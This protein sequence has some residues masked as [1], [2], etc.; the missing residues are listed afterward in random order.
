MEKSLLQTLL[1]SILITTG[2]VKGATLPNAPPGPLSIVLGD[3]FII[4]EADMIL[5]IHG[6]TPFFDSQKGSV[7]LISDINKKNIIRLRADAHQSLVVTDISDNQIPIDLQALAKKKKV[8]FAPVDASTDIKK[9]GQH[10]S[11][12]TITAKEWPTGLNQKGSQQEYYSGS[13]TPG[14]AIFSLSGLG[15]QGKTLLP[16]N[17][18][19]PG[20]ND[21][22]ALRSD[23]LDYP[24]TPAFLEVTAYINYNNYP[25]TGD[26]NDTMILLRFLAEK[27]PTATTFYSLLHAMF[28]DNLA[29]K[30]E[31][32]KRFCKK[33]QSL[34]LKKLYNYLVA[35]KQREI[36]NAPQTTEGAT[37][38]A[39]AVLTESEN[40]VTA[41]GYM[42]AN[43]IRSGHQRNR[44]DEIN[45]V[46]ERFL[47]PVAVLPVQKP[48]ASQRGVPVWRGGA[49]TVS[50]DDGS[51]GGTL[52]LTRQ[53][54]ETIP[55][56]E[57]RGLQ[58]AVQRATGVDMELSDEGEDEAAAEPL[59]DQATSGDEPLPL[60]C[61]RSGNIEALSDW[62]DR[63]SELA[64][65]SFYS[66]FYGG[67]VTLLHIAVQAGNEA[68][69]QMLIDHHSDVNAVSSSGATP[70]HF[71]AE[72]GQEQ[73]VRTLVCNGANINIRDS[74][75]R[76]PLHSAALHGQVKC[77]ER[78]LEFK[79]IGNE[80][81]HF[82]TTPLHLA[83]MM[84]HDACV[85]ALLFIGPRQKRERS[86][87]RHE[88]N[89][90]A[91]RDHHH[92]AL[93]LAVL[94]G[95]GKCAQILLDHG[96]DINA[97][98]DKGKTLLHVLTRSGPINSLQVLLDRGL[99]VDAKDDNGWTAL[100]VAAFTGRMD[101][102][103]LL[104][105]HNASLLDA[106]DNGG[107]TPLHMA[108]LAG[109]ARCV[110]WLLHRQANVNC[111]NNRN[112]S[113]LSSAAHQGYPECVKLLLAHGAGFIEATTEP[114]WSPLH[115]ATDQG[116]VECVE[117]LLGAGHEV[118]AATSDG[119]T[120]LHRATLTP[121]R[122]SVDILL[123][124][125]AN[126]QALT[127]GNNTPLHNTL[128]FDSV[129]YLLAL[130]RQGADINARTLYGLTPLHIAAREGSVKCLKVLL[131]H[132]AL[133][134]SSQRGGGWTPM[135]FASKNDH[136]ECLRLLMMD[137]RVNI[138]PVDE[139]GFTPLH[140]AAQFGRVRCMAVLLN[141]KD[142]V[143]I[144]L[145]SNRHWSPLHLAAQFGQLECVQL[146]LAYK[147]DINIR[148]VQGLTPL[149]LAVMNGHVQ[150]VQVLIDNNANISATDSGGF[151]PGFYA[152]RHGHS[153]CLE[154]LI[155]KQT[156]SGISVNELKGGESLLHHAA[157]CS[158]IDC[159]QVLINSG[160]DVNIA[161]PEGLTPL[162][163]AMKRDMAKTAQ[164]LIHNGANIDAT[165]SMGR[166]VL[167]HAVMLNA[168]RSLSV[169]IDSGADIH[170]RDCHGQTP[171]DLARRKKREQLILMLEKA[172][173]NLGNTPDTA[174]P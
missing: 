159:A 9:T 68:C 21:N 32:M 39:S 5:S 152:A 120:A 38:G 88:E 42:I 134:V 154:L 84:G 109:N 93:H 104:L 61:C 13:L 97:L 76:S 146:L 167:H 157:Q 171:L 18:G 25:D 58:C 62:L 6:F 65:Q 121:Q 59:Y 55:R 156:K 74:M 117:L 51:A 16:T 87:V 2:T 30:D 66:A 31:F 19:L 75:G 90:D 17:Y 113:P 36:G 85:A 28:P 8:F 131:E 137:K 166:T 78:F 26:I 143:H 101:F 141:A 10:F 48:S 144:N 83:A 114:G 169:L 148:N 56:G 106:T 122:N 89:I 133:I 108:A 15:D 119:M 14:Q 116:H 158:R 153:A 110:E 155:D 47:A 160:A 107:S 150:C 45:A 70:L 139:A 170:A 165:S 129:E 132:Q 49:N 24:L 69:V 35:K 64:G 173:V 22:K 29:G 123:K 124:Y 67:Y 40:A 43:Q 140:I 126:I 102:L 77:V 4:V 98:L 94:N 99:A 79:A 37:G 149:H 145:R 73:C 162:H 118:N 91:T 100:H 161:S 20:I 41:L 82:E 130:I 135:H 81:D 138:N 7:L 34:K 136:S 147:A 60:Q 125:G 27:S 52:M 12:I 53:G 44:N 103:E 164:F 71:A 111:R 96:A 95:H 92:T 3:G 128:M 163:K 168:I 33:D 105:K 50:V 115:S 151:S 11:G 127:E 1:I 80:I 174:G 46:L 172:E 72:F 63:E 57:L 54:A 23:F 86:W 112:L 142:H